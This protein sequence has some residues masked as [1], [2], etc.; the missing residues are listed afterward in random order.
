MANTQSRPSAFGIPRGWAVV[1][2][3]GNMR[4][5]GD[6]EMQRCYARVEAEYA[7]KKTTVVSLT[8]AEWQARAEQI[9]QRSA[10]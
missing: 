7:Q 3:L 8:T 5:Y 6:K 9:R 10:A 1:A 4:I 2:N